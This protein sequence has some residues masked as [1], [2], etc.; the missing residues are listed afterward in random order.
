[1]FHLLLSLFLL[2]VAA[3]AYTGPAPLAMGI[4]PWTGTT[5]LYIVAGGGAF[6]LISAVLAFLAKLRLLFLLWSLAVVLFLLRGYAS[7]TYRFAAGEAAFALYLTV[8]A[9]LALLG[10][11]SCLRSPAGKARIYRT[12]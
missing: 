10:A 1:L 12:K 11:W 6:G 3:L 4:L 5:L 8:G 2:A 7:F 9:L